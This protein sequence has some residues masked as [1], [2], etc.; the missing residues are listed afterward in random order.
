MR[1]TPW[2]CREQFSAGQVLFLKLSTT[3]TREGSVILFPNYVHNLH[4]KLKLGECGEGRKWLRLPRGRSHRLHG[5][6][7]ALCVDMTISDTQDV[8]KKRLP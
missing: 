1:T 2:S 6:L 4:L 8:C 7:C 5:Q 3:Y